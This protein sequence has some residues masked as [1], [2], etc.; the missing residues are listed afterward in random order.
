MYN[1]TKKTTTK[2][3]PT[4]K[5]TTT[6]TT[7]SK[8]K[9]TQKPKSITVCKNNTGRTTCTPEYMTLVSNLTPAL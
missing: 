8:K 4:I 1:T 9:H 3:K 6:I 5:E 7:S 2:K